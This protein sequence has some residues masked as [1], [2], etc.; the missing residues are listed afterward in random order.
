MV[1]L[2]GYENHLS[3]YHHDKRSVSPLS[4]IQRELHLARFRNR[5]HRQ[6]RP[7]QVK[8]ALLIPTVTTA[9]I[10]FA[11]PD[12]HPARQLLA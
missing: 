1:Y 12:N 6:N 2:T 4:K 5:R 7:F 9:E 3:N 11:M 10:P 8:I